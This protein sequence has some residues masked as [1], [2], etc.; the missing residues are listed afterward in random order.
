MHV[1]QRIYDL[2]ALANSDSR[3]FPATIYYNEGWLLRLVLDWFSRQKT[4]GHSLTLASGARWYSEA[5][6]PSQFLPRSRRDEL[7]EGHTHA[8]GVFGH[9]SVG[10]G[11]L[12]DVTLSKNASQFVVTEAK[13]FSPLSSGVKN[14]SYFDQAARNVACIAHVLREAQLEPSRLSSLAFY[15]LAPQEQIEDKQLFKK[16]MSKQSIIEKVSRRVGAYQ[17]SPDADAKNEWQRQ[18]FVPTLERTEIACLAW[19]SLI[20]FVRSNDEPFGTDLSNFYKDCCK[21]NRAQEPELRAIA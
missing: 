13:L 11:A 14:A 10:R 12:A 16:L 4:T 6:L 3:N 19:E 7:A 20:E 1:H 8:D 21:F 15:V 17:G 2:L 5:L 18:W 9:I